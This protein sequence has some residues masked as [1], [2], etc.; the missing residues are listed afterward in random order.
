[1]AGYC[2]SSADPLYI[3]HK[4]NLIHISNVVCKMKHGFNLCTE[5]NNSNYNKKMFSFVNFS[6]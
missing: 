2:V 6:A 1:M 4:S 5:R 3:H